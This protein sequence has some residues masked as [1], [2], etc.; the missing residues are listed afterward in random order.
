MGRT[1]D[2]PRVRLAELAH[3]IRKRAGLTQ[4]AVADKTDTGVGAVCNRETGIRGF[5]RESLDAYLVGVG[6]RTQDQIDAWELF[7]LE[8]GHSDAE[9]LAMAKAKVESSE[10]AA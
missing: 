3:A 9:A 1:S 10:V 4:K 5:S 2:T 8:A 7:F 6:A